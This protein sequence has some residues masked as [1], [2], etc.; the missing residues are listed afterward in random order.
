MKK[1]IAFALTLIILLGAI[2]LSVFAAQTVSTSKLSVK[3]VNGGA[4]IY[5]DGEY[6]GETPYSAKIAMGSEV[7]LV[8]DDEQFICYADANRNALSESKTYTFSY[9][10]EEL[11]Y[12]FSANTKKTMVIY[13]NTN[14]TKQILSYATYSDISGMETH[15]VDNA[16][17]FGMQF[18]S[19]DKTVDEIIALGQS[20]QKV[21]Y[22]TPTYT[23]STETC[24]ITTL[25]GTVNGGA[26]ATVYV[27]AQ[28]TLV[29]KE[30]PEAR[31][32]PRQ[33]CELFANIYSP[34]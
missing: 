22:V 23:T 12:V 15:L 7:T 19:W 17:I 33:K 24:D 27:G 13:R 31:G 20:G 34:A 3:G 25:N 10:G 11:I 4:E 30:A 8:T 2:N 26:T 6:K 29:A 5:V 32:F 21:I 16:S 1:L 28:I 14:D 18:L 9:T